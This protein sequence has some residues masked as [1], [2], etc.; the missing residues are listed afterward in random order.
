MITLATERARP[1]TP[2]YLATQNSKESPEPYIKPSL[3]R[4]QQK[5]PRRAKSSLRLDTFLKRNKST[6]EPQPT[7][8]LITP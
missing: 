4:F 1:K 2:D 8:L 7:Q 6:L 3:R 5:V